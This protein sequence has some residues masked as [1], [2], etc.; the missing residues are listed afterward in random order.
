MN[1][2]PGPQPENAGITPGYGRIPSTG[3]RL[4]RLE[5]LVEKFVA[6]MDADLSVRVER[7]R[8]MDVESRMAELERENRNLRAELAEKK[9]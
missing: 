2:T 9:R 7:L 3:D 5:G 4:T 8:L 6:L 1:L